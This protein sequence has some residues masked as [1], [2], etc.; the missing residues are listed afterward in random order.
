MP[1]VTRVGRRLL[2]C[3]DFLTS[4]GRLEMVN[5]VLSS[6]P[7]FYLTTL[8]LYAGIVV[9][10]DKY[11]QHC[12][13]RKKG[14]ENKNPPLAAWQL[15]CKPK[16]QGGLGVINLTVQ[17]DCLLL[18]HLDKFFNHADQPW[19]H[20][21][22]EKYYQT[23]LPPAKMSECSFWWRDCLKLLGK[24]KSMATCTLGMGQTVLLWEDIWTNQRLTVS[25]PHLSSFAINPHITV[26]QAVEPVS[27]LDMFHLPL[28]VEAFEEFHEFVTLVE[29][30]HSQDTQDVWTYVWGSKYAAKKAYDW[31]HAGPAPHPAFKWLWKS[32]CQKKHKVFGWLF[33]VDRLNTREILLRKTFFLEE[34]SCVMC[35]SD[36]IEA[37]DHLFFHCP[38]AKT[39]WRALA[40]TADLMGFQGLDCLMHLRERIGKPFFME[41][42]LMGLWAIW[43]TRNA[44]IFQ[45][46]T[47]SLYHCR[48]IFKEEMLWLKLRAGRKA[49]TDFAVWVD[50]FI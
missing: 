39:C 3:S 46:R 41:I 24:Y 1:L 31:L 40:P 17:N 48:A 32:C 49:Y 19:V 42:I 43:K 33:L 14:L 7:T 34:Y 35:N 26:K 29:E 4:A 28:S 9:Q 37:R 10:V 21:I 27:M 12:L 8:K 13:W 45:Q 22:W 2:T 15:V 47:P 11:R 25:F 50:S 38:F 6:L 20:L 30:H 18:K 23:D 44:F 5:S 16:D 36:S